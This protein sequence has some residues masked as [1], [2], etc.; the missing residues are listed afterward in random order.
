MSDSLAGGSFMGPVVFA[1]VTPNM[2]IWREEIF[3]P[4]LSVTPF[5][6][7]ADAVRLA[8]DTD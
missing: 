7:E 5:K 2:R 8:N 4:V 3:G 1:D 6:T